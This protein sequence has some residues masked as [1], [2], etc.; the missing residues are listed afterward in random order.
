MKAFII[1]S[2]ADREAAGACHRHLAALGMASVVAL[3]EAAT[4]D[5]LQPWEILT[6]FPRGER[7]KGTACAIGI[8]EMMASESGVVCKLDADMLLSPASVKWL[9]SVTDRAHGYGWKTGKMNW[10]GCWSAP[11]EVMAQVAETLRAFPPCDQCG[12]GN[13]MHAA[14]KATCGIRRF[15]PPAVQ[16]WRSGR[17]IYAD[18]HV[19]TLP[20]GIA[21]SERVADL[22]E[23]FGCLV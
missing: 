23:L 11:A 16:I 21:A 12:E 2:E 20:S 8:A 10:I 5:P 13:L 22:R 3:E 17:S 15:P 18:A 14:F 6:S 1:S 19:V 4:I 7:I 9:S